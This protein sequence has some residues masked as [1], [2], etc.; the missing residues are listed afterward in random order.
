MEVPEDIE[1]FIV[2]DHRGIKE[3]FDCFCMTG[4]TGAYLPVG[5]VGFRPAGIP[6][7]GSDHA[8]DS[9]EFGLN[10]EPQKTF[11]LAGEIRALA[12]L[13]QAAKVAF[14]I[15]CSFSIY[16]ISSRDEMEVAVWDTAM[17]GGV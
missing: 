6:D 10:A 2:R 15:R 11:E 13:E 17:R 16:R 5:G 9:P 7:T 14:S 4:L 12:V 8:F 1:Q 3:H